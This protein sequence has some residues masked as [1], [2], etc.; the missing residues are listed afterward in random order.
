MKSNMLPAIIAASAA[1][2]LAAAATAQSQF[3]QVNRVF[4]DDSFDENSLYGDQPTGIG[5]DGTTAYLG[6]LN[7]GGNVDSIGIVAVSD[8][9]GGFSTATSD[10]LA[11]T[12]LSAVGGRGYNS[13]AYDAGTDS[14][15]AG[16]DSGSASTSVYARYDPA[17]GSADFSVNGPSGVRPFVVGSDPMT[18]NG[19][20]SYAAFLSQG[21]G[22]RL[23]LDID[24]GSLVFSTGQPSPG[25]A[26][27]FDGDLGS[28]FRGMDFNSDGDLAFATVNGFGIYERTGNNTF[29]QVGEILSPGINNLGRDIAILEGVGANGEDLYAISARGSTTLAGQAIDDTNVYITDLQGNIV[30]TLTGDE[31]GLSGAFANNSKQLDFAFAPDG[32]P[33]LAI[34][35]LVE[36]RLD[37]YQVAIPEPTS[38]ALAGLGSLALLRRRRTA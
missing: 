4:V 23:A 33:T 12:V 35:S 9:Y 14:I 5:F 29:S 36:R 37:I 2:S 32:S 27:I 11:G 3:D 22:R 18:D 7:N 25:G 1:V 16:Y 19:D 17:A 13:V 38:L 15:L 34:A 31:S 30:Q 24:D 6:G 21:S 28:A 10:P 8:L 20:P 26:I